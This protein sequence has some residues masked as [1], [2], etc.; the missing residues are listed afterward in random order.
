LATKFDESIERLQNEIDDL[1]KK[2]EMAAVC[3]PKKHDEVEVYDKSDKNQIHFFF[4]KVAAAGFH[5]SVQQI[6]QT[7]GNHPLPPQ[8]IV[9]IRQFQGEKH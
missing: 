2:T 3:V 1:R 4:R 6:L 8:P 7:N 9:K 5:G